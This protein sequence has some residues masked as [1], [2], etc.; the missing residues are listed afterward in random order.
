MP[1]VF[2]VEP[3]AIGSHPESPSDHS[4]RRGIYAIRGMGNAKGRGGLLYRTGIKKRRK[5]ENADAPA[6][7]GHFVETNPGEQVMP[8][9]SAATIAAPRQR[10]PL[11]RRWRQVRMI[12]G[13][14]GEL[15]AI[16]H[17]G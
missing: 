11:G 17:S 4:P 2:L 12:R 15:D 1:L 16:I 13:I 9:E 14:E 8:T 10:Q 3:Q 5:F 7:V 6:G